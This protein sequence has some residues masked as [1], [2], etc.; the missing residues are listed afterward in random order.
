[1]RILC[2]GKLFVFSQLVVFLFISSCSS[3][4]WTSIDDADLVEGDQVYKVKT[5]AGETVNFRSRPRLSG[6][7]NGEEI[8]GV[9]ESGNEL[10]L[11]LDEIS[12]IEMA[13]W[14]P[15]MTYLVYGS[16]V[17]IIVYLAIELNSE[18]PDETPAPVCTGY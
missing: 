12:E 1:M 9:D 7:F 4:Y 15:G 5:L 16:L 8:C 10:T 6:I 18:G 11:G 3:Y 13:A 14:D 2:A 17:A